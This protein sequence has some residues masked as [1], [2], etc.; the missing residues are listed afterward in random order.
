M[1]RLGPARAE[2]HDLFD[3][4]ESKRVEVKFSRALAAHDGP[5]TTDNVLRA[6]EAALF[7]R[8]AV[9][10]A[11]AAS[12][13]LTHLQHSAG[14]CAEFDVLY[15]GIFFRDAMVV[16]RAESTEIPRSPG[17]SGKQHKGNRAREGQFPFVGNVRM[18]SQEP[19]LRRTDV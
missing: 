7:E 12:E 1:Q 4:M 18:A 2:F 3:E 6:I 14:E 5:I 10:I 16:F 17:Y 11:D 15:Y 9:A 19:V 13:T 8:K